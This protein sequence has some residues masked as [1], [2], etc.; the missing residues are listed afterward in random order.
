MV[1]IRFC[2]KIEGSSA[3]CK[4]EVE[5]H[6]E[7]RPFGHRASLLNRWFHHDVLRLH[8]APYLPSDNFV[9]WTMEEPCSTFEMIRVRK[10]RAVKLNYKV[11]VCSTK[12]KVEA[13]M[14]VG[15][16][17]VGGLETIF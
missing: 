10:T 12:K 11:Q 4:D 9:H 1:C 15:N 3:R 7:F 2:G 17:Y 13:F 14:A 6:A 16:E 8:S 5:V